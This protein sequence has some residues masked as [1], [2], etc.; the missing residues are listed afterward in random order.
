MKTN[1]RVVGVV[2]LVVA[3]VLYILGYGAWT[4]FLGFGVIA[5]M[6]AWVLI[7]TDRFRKDPNDLS[8]TTPSK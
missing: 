4:G 8:A 2:L 6:T 5:E 7:F 3:G 1:L